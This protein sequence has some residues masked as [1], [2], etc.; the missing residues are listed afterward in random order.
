MWI[1]SNLY[2]GCFDKI[3]IKCFKGGKKD[4]LSEI[5]LIFI[6]YIIYGIVILFF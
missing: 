1:I 5:S 3:N 4:V 6:V 2:V